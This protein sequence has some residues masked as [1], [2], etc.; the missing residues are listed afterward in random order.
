MAQFDAALAFVVL[1]LLMSLVVTALVQAAIA[2]FDIRGGNLKSAITTI[3]EQAGLDD[4]AKVLA[5]KVVTHPALKGAVR[6]YRAKAV[7][8]EE[9]RALLEGPGAK[10]EA[11]RVGLE[12]L[13]KVD[14][15]FDTVMHR[16]SDWFVAKTRAW[17]V[18]LS[19]ALAWGLGVDAI[20][21]YGRLARDPGPRKPS[22]LGR[23][24]D[25]A[26]RA[27]ARRHADPAGRRACGGFRRW[28][29]GLA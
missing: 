19:F 15:W 22:R 9:L 23:R 8:R 28:G 27:D 14:L 13:N 1:L 24:G 12:A 6:F 18:A 29:R 2:L 5:G 11:L 20:D 17:T 7:S 10:D 4:R 3:L 21:T 26:G 16:S 25:P